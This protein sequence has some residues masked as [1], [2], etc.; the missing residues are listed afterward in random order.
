[1]EKKEN[2][3]IGFFRKNPYLNGVLLALLLFISLLLPLITSK[4]AGYD[5]VSYSFYKVLPKL[6][7]S[8]QPSSP[9][10]SRQ[11]A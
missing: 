1:M 4:T 7:S 3:V 5:P 9:R 6:T 8:L 11:Q 10:P 2:V